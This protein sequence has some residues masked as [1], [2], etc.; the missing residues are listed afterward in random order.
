MGWLY[1]FT[2]R[3]DWNPTQK[4]MLCELNFEDK[5]LV[6]CKRTTLWNLDPIPTK[7]SNEL[8]NL[9]S[10]LPTSTTKL[11]PPSRRTFQADQMQE[12]KSKNIIRSINDINQSYI[13]T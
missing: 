1:S 12:F 6:K 2:N 4:S 3:V 8:G 9:P 7:H 5:Y 13:S 10:V 11:K